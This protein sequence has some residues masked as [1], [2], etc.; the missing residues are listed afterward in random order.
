MAR[1][2]R[3]YPPEFRQQMVELISAGRSPHSLSQEFEASG[4][5]IRN[6][7]A[8]AERDQGKRKDGLTSSEREELSRLRREI[9][10]VK[11]ERDILEKAAAWF[12][13]ETETKRKRCSAHIALHGVKRA[14]KLPRD[15]SNC[16]APPDHHS[17]LHCLLPGKRCS[18][19]KR[20]RSSPRWVSFTSTQWISIT[21][22]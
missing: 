16:H 3:A 6:W 11:V 5:A 13:Q 4:Q 10:Q 17:D 14:A 19:T 21:W 2:R 7:V 18:A 9:R 12:A 8:Q 22:R 20:P 1:G 15:L